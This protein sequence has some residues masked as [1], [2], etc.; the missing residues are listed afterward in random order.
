LVDERIIE[1]LT[2]TGGNI[3]ATVAAPGA[4]DASAEARYLDDLD[5]PESLAPARKG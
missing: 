4:S 2:R 3:V 5:A 1:G